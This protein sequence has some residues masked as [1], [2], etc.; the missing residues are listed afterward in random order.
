MSEE[1]KNDKNSGKKIDEEWKK[2]L[3]KEKEIESVKEE[4]DHTYMSPPPADFGLFVSSLMLEALMY[5]GE[6]ENPATKLKEQNL[7]QARYIIDT[8]S[9]LN[10]KVKGNLTKEEE[11]MMEGVLY[12]LR[13]KFVS[14]MNAI[15]PP[16]IK[17]G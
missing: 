11:G 7:P 9:M 15:V 6:V 2:S 5:L 3:E 13:T 10:D 17:K 1:N 12:E 8:I 14:K 4:F 16:D